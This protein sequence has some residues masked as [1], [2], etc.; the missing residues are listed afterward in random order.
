MAQ[1][2][3]FLV[4]IRHSCM[5]ISFDVHHLPYNC[6]LLHWLQM[7]ATPTPVRVV[8]MGLG[9]FAASHGTG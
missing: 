9:L 1:A 8:G 4:G 7:K 2:K 5:G 3:A 6:A